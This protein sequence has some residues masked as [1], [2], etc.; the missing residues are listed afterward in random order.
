MEK[1]FTP[2]PW[3]YTT[4]PI[5]NIAPFNA[6][7]WKDSKFDNGEI[8]AELIAEVAHKKDAP[9]IAA[10]AELLETLENYTEVMERFTEMFPPDV[11]ADL[12]TV[13]AVQEAHDRA[14]A[15]INK[16]YGNEN[17]NAV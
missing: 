16:A 8:G 5:E 14:K 11:F 15:V 7:I 4:N 2:G 17:S 6:S 9:I 12:V 1:K 10:S 13:L 3:H